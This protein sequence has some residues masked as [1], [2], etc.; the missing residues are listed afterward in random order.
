MSTSI[1]GAASRMES[2]GTRLWPPASTFAPGSPTRA[3]T[4]SVSGQGRQ[5]GEGCWLHD[6]LLS[7]SVLVVA[8]IVRLHVVLGVGTRAADRD[9]GPVVAVARGDQRARW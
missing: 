5:I 6:F 9:H 7:A 2:N 3:A 8:V 1:D 4:A